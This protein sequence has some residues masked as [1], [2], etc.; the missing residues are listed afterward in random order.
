MG[1]H[2]YIKS[3]YCVEAEHINRQHPTRPK[4]VTSTPHMSI[5]SVYDHI[6]LMR[7]FGEDYLVQVTIYHKGKVIDKWRNPR[8]GTSDQ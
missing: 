6:K 8:F 4:V 7:K 3:E 1:F 5:Y 2:S